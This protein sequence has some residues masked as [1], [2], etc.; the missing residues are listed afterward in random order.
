MENLRGAFRLRKKIGRAR[1][2]R[3]SDRRYPHYRFDVKRMRASLAR[4]RRALRLRRDRGA[5]INHGHFQKTRDQNARAAR[6]ATFRR[7]LFQKCPG[8]DEVIHEIEL[9]ENQRVCPRCDYHFPQSAKERIENLLDPGQLRGNGREFA[10][11]RHASDFKAWP[12]TRI[13]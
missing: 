11:S 13:A 7:D 9:I 12:L 4:S 6:S 2:A 10:L 3:A 1:I 8:C 5:R